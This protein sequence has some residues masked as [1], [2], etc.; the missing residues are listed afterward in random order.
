MH[1]RPL[2]V[3]ST[4]LLAALGCS[5]GTGSPTQPSA[6]QSDLP[7]A[8]ALAFS[9]VSSGTIHTCAVAGDGSLYCWG[10]NYNG[11]LGNTAPDTCGYGQECSTTPWAVAGGHR[12]K[13]V[14]AGHFRTCGLAT[15]DRAYCWGLGPLGNGTEEASKTPVAVSGDLRFRRLD[16]SDTHACG[17]TANNRAYCWGYNNLGQLGDGTTTHRLVPVAVAGTRA[18]KLV[19][20]GL[21]HTCGLTTEERAY[22]WGYNHEGQLGDS[23]TAKMR[24]R[25]S[26]VAGSHQFRQLDA[27]DWHT[28]GVT[29][30]GEAYCW[31]NGRWGQLGNGR[32]YLSFWPRRVAG[33]LVFERVTAGGLHSCGETEGNRAYCWGWSYLLGT[34]SSSGPDTCIY[35][36]PC[37]TRPV[38]VRG[39]RTFRQVSAGGTQTC[40]RTAAGFAYCWGMNS[41]GQLGD[42]TT[43]DRLLPAAVVGPT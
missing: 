8:A 32:S 13:S 15:D 24:R 7:A 11:Q 14:S 21:T 10:N 30:E 2:I 25:P 37:S 23:S 4:L 31:G 43:E 38:A 19:S 3:A 5:D 18:F 22:C 17:V 28:C 16:V 33:K 26:P 40:A 27:G 36:D 20:T 6:A 34:G 9:Q 1:T 29:P 35:G 12:F 42:G 41:S 39:G